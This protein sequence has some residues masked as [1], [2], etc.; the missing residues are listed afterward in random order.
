MNQRKIRPIPPFQPS[1]R[2]GVSTPWQPDRFIGLFGTFFTG[3]SR[4]TGAEPRNHHEQCPGGGLPPSRPTPLQRS[5]S[6][7][8]GPDRF[9]RD[10]QSV[11]DLCR[12]GAR[13]LARRT[14]LTWATVS[15][16]DL[17]GVRVTGRCRP[18][19][20]SGTSLDVF[21]PVCWCK[22][23]N[24]GASRRA[25]SC[26]CAVCA[27]A[28]QRGGGLTRVYDVCIISSVMTRMTRHNFFLDPA[29]ARCLKAASRDEEIP[30]AQI[31]PEVR[32]GMAHC[33][34]LHGAQSERKETPTIARRT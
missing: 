32:Q 21:R 11:A 23:A 20:A 12:S 26:R 13:R 3:G 2:A 7:G 28:S 4:P 27:S 6:R 14:A 9:D 10:G 1:P 19:R 33:Q 8:P 15:L 25:G 18:L 34:W 31:V 24:R 22:G 29:M 16:L 30:Q 5:R 17:P